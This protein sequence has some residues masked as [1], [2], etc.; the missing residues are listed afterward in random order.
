MHFLDTSHRVRG[1]VNNPLAVDVIEGS[2]G[3][4][5]LLCVPQPHVG[6]QPEEPASATGQLDRA[7]GQIT[8]IDPRSKTA[9]LVDPKPN[10][11]SNVQYPGP[12]ANDTQVDRWNPSG[13]LMERHRF[14]FLEEL[15]RA[16]IGARL[17]RVDRV[18]IPESANILKGGF[19]RH[20]LIPS[21]GVLIREGPPDRCGFAF[22]TSHSLLAFIDQLRPAHP[23]LPA[24]VATMLD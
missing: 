5:Q 12:G 1:V 4:R 19:C 22:G 8:G 10:T 13:E 21:T 17:S 9:E 11:A 15:S 14:V 20:P 18:L 2:V 6:L 3:I 23:F 16:G 7:A 24:P